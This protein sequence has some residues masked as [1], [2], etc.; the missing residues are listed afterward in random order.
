MLDQRRIAPRQPRRPQT[1]ARRSAPRQ[2]ATVNSPTLVRKCFSKRSPQRFSSAVPDDHA[3]ARGRHDEHGVLGRHVQ[4]PLGKA[5]HQRRHHQA[6]NGANRP[7]H[8]RQRHDRGRAARSARC[9]GR[10]CQTP[11][12]AS[13]SLDGTCGS[14]S[15]RLLGSGQT[16]AP[17]STIAAAMLTNRPS[18]PPTLAS[19]GP[20]TTSPTSC[21]AVN[22]RWN[23]LLACSS[24]RARDDG[25]DHRRLGGREELADRRE[26]RS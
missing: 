24:L 15:P 7:L 19:S 25:R 16:S 18:T 2:A 4:Q 8:H 14:C 21:E 6:E 20:S 1:P 17:H 22:V 10:R 13:C 26:Q 9:P 3:D 23:R 5:R 11:R 12:I